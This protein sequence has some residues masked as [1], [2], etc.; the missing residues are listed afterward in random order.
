MDTFECLDD[1]IVEIVS[2]IKPI[3]YPE[4]NDLNFLAKSTT[5]T[6]NS[7]IYEKNLR[8]S[9]AIGSLVYLLLKYHEKIQMVLS[10]N[11]Y[12]YYRDTWRS[13]RIHD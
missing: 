12:I 8:P 11:S 5:K 9:T 13:M 1:I 2:N 6:L 3:T 4:I 7:H 10:E